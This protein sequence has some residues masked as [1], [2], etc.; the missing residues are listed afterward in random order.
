MLYENDKIRV[1][2]D[3]ILFSKDKI[4]DQRWQTAFVI[5]DNFAMRD[6]QLEMAFIFDPSI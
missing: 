2:H 1:D 3:K 5:I 4:D 6:S